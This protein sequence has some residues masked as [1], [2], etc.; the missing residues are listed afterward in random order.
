MAYLRDSSGSYKEERISI[1]ENPV[2]ILAL[3]VSL[4]FSA[5]CGGLVAVAVYHASGLVTKYLK[6]Y[7]ITKIKTGREL[8][9]SAT[10]NG[11]G[12]NAFGD[13][14]LYFYSN[15]RENEIRNFSLSMFQYFEHKFLTLDSV[16]YADSLMSYLK[17]AKI[18]PLCMTNQIS[19]RIGI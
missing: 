1:T 3:V 7:F 17:M 8:I 16:W 12:K 4:V 6:E 9:R 14:K 10:E 15:V 18:L 2:L 5:F 19:I 13:D 11:D